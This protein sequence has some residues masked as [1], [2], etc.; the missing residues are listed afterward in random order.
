M[1]RRAWIRQ[2]SRRWFSARKS[3]GGS[4]PSALAAAGI[5]VG[6]AALIVVLGVMNGFQRGYIDTILEV[7]SYDVR[8]ETAAGD[9]SEADLLSR[10]RSQKGVKCA[11]PFSEAQVLASGSDGRSQPLRVRTVPRDIDRMDPGFVAALGLP[12]GRLGD[13][14][15]LVIGS[16]FARFL[17][18]VPGDEIDVLGVSA[19]REEGISTW[20]RRLP[21]G[22]VFHSGFYDFDMGLAFVVVGGGAAASPAAGGALSVAGGASR[23][24][25]IKLD[26]RNRDSAFVAKL[27]A[28]GIEGATG[29]RDYNKAFFGALRTEKT[30][31]MLLVGLIFA[32]VGVN[33]FQSMRRGVHERMEEIAL[34]RSLGG[35]ASEIQGIFVADGLA[36]GFIGAM[37]GLVL[38]LLVASNVNGILAVSGSILNWISS[39]IAGLSGGRPADLSVYS[40]AYFYLMEVPVKVLYPETVF[41]V[42][43]AI[44]SAGAA[45]ASAAGRI[46]DYEPAELL[47]HE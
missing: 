27:E 43:A 39:A 29:W 11:V 3:A 8:L 21:V 2:V 28:M 12:E 47:R 46:A 15:G 26:D 45:A 6:V 5:G 30:I 25:G 14:K 44:A 31:M 23:S 20:S 42:G 7:S 19:D 18:V 35:R 16:E 4:G 9:G 38:G 41:V 10:I 1:N 17:N 13:I 33:I 34:L 37:S 40:P 24:I 32:V 22:A 36:I